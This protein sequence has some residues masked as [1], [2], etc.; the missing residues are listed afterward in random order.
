VVLQVLSDTGIVGAIF[1]FSAIIVAVAGVLWP[2]L[3]VGFG[4]LGRAWRGDERGPTRSRWGEEPMA[5]GWQMALFAGTTYWFVHANM[6]WLWPVPGVT[7][8]AL[9]MLGAGVAAT[10]AL[11]GTMWSG[12]SRRVTRTALPGNSPEEAADGA[13]SGVPGSAVTEM[14]GRWSPVGTLRPP[15]LLSQAFRIALITVSAFVLIL[16]GSAYLLLL[17]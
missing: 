2:R 4:R 7:V 5:S 17:F 10:D 3:V 16:A 6:E 14:K 13:V 11:A 12:L 9:L 15:G 8:P 1:G